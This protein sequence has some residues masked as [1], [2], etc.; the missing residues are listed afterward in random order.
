[1]T[2]KGGC[3]FSGNGCDEMTENEQ[4]GISVLI[5]S[6]NHAKYL[7]ETIDSVFAQTFKDVECVVVDGGSTDG[8]IDI[9]KEYPQVRWISEKETDA[10]K[11]LEAFRK[12][13]ALSRGRYIIQCCV[14]DGFTSRRWF[15]L[16]HDRLEQDA[17][18]SLV[19]GLPQY[20]TEDGDLGK[21]T[22]PE[23]LVK[24]PPQ[25]KDFLAFWFATFYGFHEG[26][27]CVRREIFDECFPRRNEPCLFQASPQIAFLYEFNTRGYLPY[28]LPVAANFGRAHANQ[29]VLSLWEPLDKEIRLYKQMI[30]EYQEDLLSGRKRH[31]FRNGAAQ[32]IGAVPRSDLGRL[33][34]AVWGHYL[35][36]KIAK[37][38]IETQERL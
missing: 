15:E 23:F 36:Y 10:N 3:L 6:F 16:C 5:P 30:K 11:V 33:R 35:K 13:F 2:H 21:V 18:I 19:W 12:A 37:R 38:L 24:P 32:V 27:Y 8:T 26:N 31:D 1:M 17:E 34:R 9:L 25:K 20:M 14:S 28:F 4:P 7:R 22:N 29:R